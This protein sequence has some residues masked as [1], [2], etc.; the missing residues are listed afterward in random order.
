VG[1]AY[2][3]FSGDILADHYQ[4]PISSEAEFNQ[5]PTRLLIAAGI[6]D[7]H[8]PG[9][10]GK[11]ARNAAG[12]PV[13][14]IIASAKLIPWQ[15]PSPPRFDPPVNFSNQITFTSY[16]RRDQRSVTPTGSPRPLM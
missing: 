15:W 11:P 13:E 7:Y 16:H 14:P 5:A 1:L 6:Y 8:E 10:P 3:A 9:R 12:E 2:Y 4:V